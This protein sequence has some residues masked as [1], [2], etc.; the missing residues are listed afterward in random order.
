MGRM[1]GEGVLEHSPQALAA[2]LKVLEALAVTEA[3]AKAMFAQLQSEGMHR[4][5]WNRMM[6]V[7]MQCCS[8]YSQHL[9]NQ[10]SFQ[11]L[12]W[13]DLCISPFRP[14]MLLP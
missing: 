9:N 11:D 12:V 10:V 13:E 7:V 6:Y 8:R 5:S 14:S 3:G 1:H 4:L 2:Y